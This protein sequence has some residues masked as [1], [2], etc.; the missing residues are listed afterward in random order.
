MYFSRNRTQTME[1]KLS[2]SLPPGLKIYEPSL[3]SRNRIKIHD[4]KDAY[5]L[6]DLF[7]LWCNDN[8]NEYFK[9]LVVTD[10]YDSGS[11][12]DADLD[13]VV[14][15]G[16]MGVREVDDRE[17]LGEPELSQQARH[18]YISLQEQHQKRIPDILQKNHLLAVLYWGAHMDYIN[19]RSNIGNTNNVSNVYNDNKFTNEQKPPMLIPITATTSNKQ[20]V[21]SI[22][23]TTR[24]S[25]TIPCND[26]IPN[27]RKI[28][29]HRDLESLCNFNKE[30]KHQKKRKGSSSS[31][32]SISMCSSAM[33]ETS[34]VYFYGCYNPMKNENFKNICTSSILPLSVLND[35]Q[36]TLYIPT[37]SLQ[38]SSSSLSM[39]LGIQFSQTKAHIATIKNLYVPC[40]LPL[41]SCMTWHKISANKRTEDNPILRYVPYF[42][43]WDTT[44]IDVSAWDILPGQCEAEISNEIDELLIVYMIH[45]SGGV[46]EKD[47]SSK[48]KIRNPAI[49]SVLCNLLQCSRKELKK[50]YKKV[51]DCTFLRLR[52]MKQRF[53]KINTSTNAY[54]NDSDMKTSHLDALSSLS[55]LLEVPKTS[56]FKNDD[57]FDTEIGLGLRCGRNYADIAQNF[58]FFFCRRCFMYNCQEHLG[59]N[60]PMPRQRKDPLFRP[61]LTLWNHLDDI[62]KSC[63]INN[64]IEDKELHGSR[65]GSYDLSSTVKKKNDKNSKHASRD[66]FFKSILSVADSNIMFSLLHPGREKEAIQYYEEVETK[67]RRERS[68]MGVNMK[69]N[70][71]INLS[72]LCEVPY[73]LYNC[74]RVIQGE[75]EINSSFLS[76]SNSLTSSSTQLS[77]IIKNVT[78][79][80]AGRSK[81]LSPSPTA[82]SRGTKRP[83]NSEEHYLSKTEQN[84]LI[85]LN[86]I[87]NDKKYSGDGYSGSSSS[88]DGSSIN[89]SDETNSKNNDNSGNSRNRFERIAHVL[90]TRKPHVV[91]AY[92]RNVYVPPVVENGGEEENIMMC[93]EVLTGVFNQASIRHLTQVQRAAGF[94]KEYRPC[95]HQGVCGP[96]AS[97]DW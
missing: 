33:K 42:G 6:D 67:R 76:S 68:G 45:M 85:K 43:E 61:E 29:F 62:D 82:T 8:N 21:P 15:Y 69:T 87:F 28:V 44:G 70:V 95:S 81:Y 77:P 12:S 54:G 14:I 30:N 83:K 35:L 38:W 80:L 34:K 18:V 17:L 71:N 27:A 72:D 31:S 91:Q 93:E 78:C 23:P 5:T 26:Q 73:E 64:S 55:S 41:P 37:S 13:N 20:N 66:C 86:E 22:A 4:S 53:E 94:Y 46:V 92:L 90:G 19:M 84:L 40:A 36:R 88:N 57:V 3:T 97:P 2:L 9:K 39:P 96:G 47:Y 74:R 56:S 48:C 25:Y 1:R 7:L 60:Q 52:D 10:M 89:N 49:Q 65:L 59:K 75:E 79:M 32:T 24:I 51:I 50:C 63:D 11:D 16:G 58:T